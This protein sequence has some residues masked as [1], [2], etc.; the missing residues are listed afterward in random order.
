MN[1]GIICISIIAILYIIGIGSISL[2]F[3]YDKPISVYHKK[4][5]PMN[6]KYSTNTS[7]IILADWED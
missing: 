7:N 2:S 6:I 1:L 3:I 4:K 5:H